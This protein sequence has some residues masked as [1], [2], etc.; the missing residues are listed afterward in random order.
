ML[1]STST[2]FPNGIAN[3]SGMVGKNFM[4]HLDTRGEA[5]LPALSFF[6]PYAGDGDRRFAYHHS[7]VWIRPP[8]E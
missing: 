5:Y 1:L 6:E 4:E 8:E 3:S 2:F 7:V